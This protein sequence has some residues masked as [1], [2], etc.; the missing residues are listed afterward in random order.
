MTKFER[1]DYRYKARERK[2]AG[3]AAD[4]RVASINGAEHN[5]IPDAHH[6]VQVELCTE[7][8]TR[9]RRPI[10]RVRDTQDTWWQA[11]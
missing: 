8:I 6:S 3:N 5:N 11:Y 7:Q 9:Y 1:K 4:S 10:Y 2:T